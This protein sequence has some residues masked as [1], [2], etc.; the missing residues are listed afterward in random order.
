MKLMEWVAAP[1]PSTDQL[2]ADEFPGQVEIV[3]WQ[4]ATILRSLFRKRSWPIDYNEF[5][6]I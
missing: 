4:M 2:F 3:K 1:A 5:I 6:G